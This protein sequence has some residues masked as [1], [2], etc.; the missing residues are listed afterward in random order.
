MAQERP[1]RALDPEDVRRLLRCSQ[2]AKRSAYC[3]YSHFPVG[4]ALLTW[5]GKVFSGCNVEN[6]CYPLGICAE[7][8]A[9]QKAISEGYKNFRAIAIASDLQDDFISPC[10]A[11]RQVMREFGS[12]WAVYMTKPDGTYVVRTVQEL[13]PASFGPED[14]QKIQ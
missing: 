10:G 6:A 14:L 12:S 7:R 2:E 5:D 1:A 9:I 3:P 4:A 8:T 13:L 11:C